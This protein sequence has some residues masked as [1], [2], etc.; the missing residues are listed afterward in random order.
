MKREGEGEKK[1]FLKILVI[2]YNIILLYLALSLFHLNREAP[3]IC[4]LFLSPIPISLKYRE[5]PL[6]EETTEF[7]LMGITAVV[8]LEHEHHG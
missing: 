5:A 8:Q 7:S 1:C 2:K 4:M 6:H 3:Y